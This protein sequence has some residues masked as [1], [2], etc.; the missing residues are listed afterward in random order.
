VFDQSEFDVRCEWGPAGLR[1]VA[2]RAEVVVIVDVLSFTT[3]VDVA[4]GRGAAVFPFPWM[5]PAS[6]YYAAAIGAVPATRRGQGYSLSPA[7]LREI[8]A[9]CKLVLPSPNG[10]AL[11]FGIEH[12]KVLAGCLRN[13]FAVATEA[14][15][16][17]RSIAVIPA[18]E[19]WGNE[20]GLRPSFEDWVGAGAIVA[21][22]AGRKSAE[23]RMA[24]AA[25]EAARGEL[26]ALMREC[27]SGKEMIGRGFP[28]D[29]EM[30]AELDVSGC[31]PRLVEGAFRPS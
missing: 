7:S 6:A 26:L 27:G 14:A 11:A 2:A 30:A 1:E 12:D 13:A 28:E 24:Q 20:G 25:F 21:G 31:A 16:M 23:A 22:L 29:V 17:G 5:R 15:R 19:I 10:S 18:G 8:P 9:G 3:A 4:V